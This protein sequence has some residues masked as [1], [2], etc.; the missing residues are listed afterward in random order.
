MKLT[1]AQAD[2]LKEVA[3]IGISSA[4]T[5]LSELLD[6]EV[7][8][9]VPEVEL[10]PANEVMS[11]INAGDEKMGIIVQELSGELQGKVHLAFLSEE[12]KALVHALIGSL[13]QIDNGETDTGLYEKEAL[14]EIGN[15]VISSCIAEFADQLGNEI[16]LTVPHFTEGR[17]SSIFTGTADKNIVVLIIKTS[18]TVLKQDVNG[19]IVIMLT[20][21]STEKI[22]RS[23]A[24]FVDAKEQELSGK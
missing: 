11:R 4:S 16:E 21:D 2:A 13:P 14:E 5:Q 20:L 7:L 17:F 19:I 24:E 10:V 8:M 6:D 12:S 3:N 1:P 9:D 23:L 15:V 18:L 22:L